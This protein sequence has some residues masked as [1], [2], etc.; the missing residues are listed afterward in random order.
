MAA[1][2]VHDFSGVSSSQTTQAPQLEVSQ[3]QWDPVSPRSSRRK[4]MSSSRGSISRVNESP[5]TVTV[6]CMSGALAAGAG[7]GA[8]QRAHGE[9]GGQ[10]LLVGGRAALVGDRAAVFGRELGGP[11]EVL[12]GRVRAAQEVL[13]LGGREVPGPHGGE[14]DP[15]VGDGTAVEPQ[16]GARGGDRPVADPPP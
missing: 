4:W 7:G 8:A 1:S 13:G 2:T 9:F 15:G 14:P 11:G 16:G 12:L 5:L 3:P 6:I 10:V